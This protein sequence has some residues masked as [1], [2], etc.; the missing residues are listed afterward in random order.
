M[1]NTFSSIIAG[2][3]LCSSATTLALEFEDQWP[4]S[5]PNPNPT[6]YTDLNPENRLQAFRSFSGKNYGI[7]IIGTNLDKDTNGDYNPNVLELKGPQQ[8]ALPQGAVIEK[9]YF[10]YA[11]SIYYNVPGDSTRK[12]DTPDTEHGGTAP[13]DSKE[14]AANNQIDIKIDGVSYTNLTPASV[15]GDSEAQVSWWNVHGSEG[16][17]KDSLFGYYQNRLD[18][19]SLVSADINEIEVTRLERIDFAGNADNGNDGLWF[20]PPAAPNGNGQKANDCH[21]GASY[22]L[23]IVYSLPSGPSKTVSIYDGL[24]WVWDND[25]ATNPSKTHSPIAGPV[26]PDLFIDHGAIESSQPVSVTIG[27]LDGDAVWRPSSTMPECGSASLTHGSGQDYTWVQTGSGPEKLYFNLYEGVSAPEPGL[28]LTD[29]PYDNYPNVTSV[30]KGMNYNVV[31]LEIE[32]ATQGAT[33]TKMH[34]Q[35][36]SSDST[37][38]WQE[39]LTLNFVVFEATEEGSGTDLPNVTLN[40]SAEVTLDLN[41][42]WTDPGAAAQDEQDGNLTDSIVV[43]G[44]VVDTT[45]AGTYVIT[46]NVTDSDGN[47]AVERTRTVTV[48][49]PFQCVEH[50]ASASSH[51]TAGRATSEVTGQTCWGTWCWGGTTSYSAI[52]SGDAMGSS[53][54]AS[55]TLAETA[56]GYY[57]VGDCG[58]VIDTEA[59]VLT[60]NGSSQVT[61]NL[62][63][64]YEEL[65][66]TAV[67]NVDGDISNQVVITGSVDTSNE[68]T[69]QLTYNVSDAAGNPA[70]TVTRTVVVEYSEDTTAPTL[71]LRGD[72][73][74][75]VA[76]NSTFTDP[77]ADAYDE[78]DGDIDHR[79]QVTGSVNTTAPGTYTLTY[80][81]SDVAGNPASPATRTVKVLEQ[82]QCTP[83]TASTYTHEQEGR[84]YKCG[85]NACAVGSD[86]DLGFWNTFNTVTL[87]ETGPNYYQ[88][89]TCN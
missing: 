59:P 10:Y 14:D 85:Y 76:Q 25:F 54:T 57:E 65:G 79:I 81:V 3:L 45:K 58:P 37:E 16:T 31:K 9:A 19:T 39:G 49:A 8:L 83:Y 73:Y 48:E 4:A 23:V 52:G 60:L 44:D 27:V 40:G 89:G 42:D 51:V 30:M 18:V 32:G 24:S 33:Q 68:G 17:L 2:T 69:Y 87:I 62:N 88:L 11:G 7:K 75:E 50:T 70:N 74:M 21:S 22:S 71:T 53:G 26:T 13:L 82:A 43:G 55:I 72:S 6:R 46:Y 38:K 56:E 28:P 5:N 12:D 84:A 80:N 67:D 66:A 64:N 86:D 29:R 36:D 77:G 34:F 78:T 20:H 61:V 47:P 35:A 15:G 41:D 1:N 63:G